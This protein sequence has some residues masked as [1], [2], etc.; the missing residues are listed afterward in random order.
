MI[1]PERENPSP[2]EESKHRIIFWV[3][4]EVKIRRLTLLNRRTCR[5]ILCRESQFPIKKDQDTMS[6]STKTPKKL[7]LSR[8]PLLRVKLYLYREKKGF[9]KM[10]PFQCTLL[11][12]TY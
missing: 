2:S 11:R 8:H 7:G 12:K 1:K 9:D 6:T 4:L 10:V 3:L 5:T